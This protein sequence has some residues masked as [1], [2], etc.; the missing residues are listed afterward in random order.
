MNH[1]YSLRDCADFLGAQLTGDPDCSITGLNS[2]GEAGP[3][4][5]TFLA[6]K[7]YRHLLATTRAAAV[8]L[9]PGDV[10]DYEGN[11]LV[12]KNPYAGYAR[13]TA[14]FNT[15]PEPA[16]GC[17]VSAVIADSAEVSPEASIGPCAVIGEG[18]V[19]ASGAVIGAGTFIGDGSSIGEGT[20]I[21]ANV[22][23]YHGVSIGANCRIHSGAVI[24]ADGFGF[25]NDGGQWVKIH[26]LGGVKIGDRVEVGACTTIDRGAL[27]DTII[28][29]GVVLDNHVQIAHNVKVG[30]NTAMA[31]FVG[32]AGSST[33]GKNCIF[34]GQAGAVGHVTICDNVQ[35]MART[36]LSKSIDKPGSYSS[37][38]H[39]YE[40]A[41][42]RK[43]A[44][45]FGQLDDM[46]RRLKALE[47][48]LK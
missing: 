17:H 16:S 8:I 11:A 39:M 22:S 12:L 42:W 5:L 24:G 29:D 23:I 30:E 40:T 31:A 32:I 41:K 26:Q 1:S 36:A 7:T 34:A 21:S 15:A 44:V 43:N 13:M 9:A 2:L 3:G 18:V 25:A 48:K 37:G 28:D 14:R 10:P 47:K 33:I 4:D 20:H 27:G 35:A 19:I 46:A 38:I 45:R 6:N